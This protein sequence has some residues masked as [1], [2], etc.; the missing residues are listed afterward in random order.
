MPDNKENTKFTRLIQYL[1]SA[2]CELIV[3]NSIHL[4]RCSKS[5]DV[6]VFTMT[7]DRIRDVLMDQV[8]RGALTSLVRI[9]R[10][11]TLHRRCCPRH[12]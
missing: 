9:H 5:M 12:Q 2:K 6:C 8:K 10:S 7:D 1:A 3:W 4:L 11:L